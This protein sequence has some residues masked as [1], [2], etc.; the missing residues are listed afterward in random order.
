MKALVP[1][2]CAVAATVLLGGCGD[3]P[4]DPGPM[5]LGPSH[6]AGVVSAHV[7]AEKLPWNRPADQ[8]AQV[9]AAGLSLTSQ[10]QLQVHYHAHLDVFVDGKRV[11]VPAGL[12]INIGPNNTMPPHGA[13]GIAPLHTHD[14]SGVLHIEA[15]RADTFTLGQAFVEWGVLLRSHQAGAYSP[16]RV[17]VAGK[18]YDGDPARIVLKP[19]E[20]IALVAGTG[21]VKVPRRYQFPPGE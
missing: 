15:A 3:A 4:Q 2:A 12:G 11:P 18:R 16:V 9:K 5:R 21:H 10:E 13:P 7:H 8:Q 20:E 1:L 17:Y 14:T 19:H 6:G